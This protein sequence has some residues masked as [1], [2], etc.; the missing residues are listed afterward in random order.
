MR[1]IGQRTGKFSRSLLFV[2]E[3]SSS[4]PSKTTSLTRSQTWPWFVPPRRFPAPFS[5]AQ[6]TSALCPGELRKNQPQQP[7]NQSCSEKPIT[8]SL[9]QGEGEEGQLHQRAASSFMANITHVFD[10][11]LQTRGQRRG[12]PKTW[13]MFAINEGAWCRW[14]W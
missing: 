2:F 1:T 12:S 4:S 9:H 13:V 11:L 6:L 8:P 10:D 3:L 14:S 7:L 5:T